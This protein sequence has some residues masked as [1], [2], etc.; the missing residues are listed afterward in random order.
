MP[1]LKHRIIFA[2]LIISSL[3]SFD[4]SACYTTG[5]LSGNTSTINMG[6]L[7]IPRDAPNGSVIGKLKSETSKSWPGSLHCDKV[8]D[9]VEFSTP[10]KIIRNIPVASGDPFPAGSLMETNIPGVGAIVRAQRIG[11][12]WER[13]E[14]EGYVPNTI[15]Y[16]SSGKPLYR[17]GSNYWVTL[18]KTGEITAGT[19]S[20][21]GLQL[22]TMSVTGVGTI[23]KLLLN[24]SITTS[25]CTL[26]AASKQ[27]E[28]SMGS[29]EKRKFNGKG[30]TSETVPFNI[31]L[32]DCEP[33]SYRTDQPWNF[34]QTSNANIRLDGINGSAP[35]SDT[36]IKGALTLNNN[37]TAKGWL[38]K[39]WTFSITRK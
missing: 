5:S 13:T 1:I 35:V 33:G 24:G 16:G 27:I 32:N 29:V 11:E 20:F 23:D 25:Q 38:C 3:Y 36:D 22:S 10:L 9:S 26:P 14:S 17:G 34:F 31:P 12:G 19:Q 2:G 37:S 8:G 21:N 6:A 7:Y 18:V 28:V 4:V 30:T 39:F 15:T